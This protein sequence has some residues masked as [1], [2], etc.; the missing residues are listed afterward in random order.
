MARNV[1]L[2]RGEAREEGGVAENALTP[3]HLVEISPSGTG[4]TQ[5]KRWQRHATAGGP[6]ALIFVR[7]QHEN[8]GGDIDDIVAAGDDVTVI[9]TELGAKVNCVTADTIVEGEWVESA[10]D[11]TVRVYGSGYRL[12]YAYN[13]SDLTETIGRVLIITAPSGV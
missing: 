10:G 4:T 11:G 2:I 3:G 13:D 12:G 1:I 9:F 6:A 5:R 7:S 8:Q